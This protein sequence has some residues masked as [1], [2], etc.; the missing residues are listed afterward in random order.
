[1]VAVDLNRSQDEI[2]LAN[3]ALNK[4]QRCAIDQLI[5]PVLGSGSDPE[6]MRMVTSVAELA[7]QCLQ[8]YSE[9]RP[10][11]NE[12][13]DVLENIQAHGRI[14]AEESKTLKPPPRSENTD[15]T[16]LLKNFPPSPV[17][18]TGEW[19]SDSTGSTT[20]SIR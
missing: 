10:T 16:V 1:M 7:F 8:F 20:L 12:V 5:D 15:T 2:S 11:M 14:D 6:V 13:L 9:M 4:I 3:L 17:S 18:V 19:H